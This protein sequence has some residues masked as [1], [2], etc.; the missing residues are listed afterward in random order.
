MEKLFQFDAYPDEQWNQIVE[1]RVYYTE[2]YMK[3]IHTRSFSA[4]ILGALGFLVPVFAFA[5]VPPTIS[6][7]ATGSGDNVQVTVYGDPNVSVL[8]SPDFR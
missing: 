5:T 3:R 4:F 6:L 1:P 7:S 2:E 8:L